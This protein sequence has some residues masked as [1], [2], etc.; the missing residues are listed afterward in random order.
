MI[1][2]EFKLAGEENQI[3]VE[4][5]VLKQKKYSVRFIGFLSA[6]AALALCFALPLLRLLQL[7]AHDD[8]YSDL[9][10]IPLVSL[11]LVWLRR[12][13]LPDRFETS[14]QPGALFAGSGL[15]VLAFHWFFSREGSLSSDGDLAFSVFALLLFFTGICFFFLGKKFV[16]IVTFP[17]S[18]LIFTV[19]FP[20]FLRQKIETFLQHGSALF[21][22]AFFRLSSVPVSR[23]GLVFHLP[24]CSLQVAPECSGIHSTLALLITSLLAGWLFL[25]SPG[26]RILLALAVLPLALARN[27]FRIFV[28]GRLCA[29]YGP[30]MLDSPIHRHG[31]P[32]FFVLSLIPFSLLLLFLRKTEPANGKSPTNKKL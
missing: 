31:G 15:L 28:I 24:N 32:L 13:D 29:A 10:L 11:Y 20:G 7:A 22:G 9:P 6:A 17:L 8:L 16:S 2:K 21:A 23:E 12:K 18:L 30:Q 4:P 14:L 3:P 1:A 19:P 27:G 25:R 5:P 26:E